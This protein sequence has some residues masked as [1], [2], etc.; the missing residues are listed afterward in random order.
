MIATRDSN[1]KREF[2]LAQ[3]WS[4]RNRKSSENRQIVFHFLPPKLF[5]R[6][7]PIVIRTEQL[8]IF[9]IA[10]STFGEWTLM[11]KLKKKLGIA[12]SS[13]SGI[14]IL[15]PMPISR[16]DLRLHSSWNVSRL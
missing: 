4:S 5:N 13:C 7:Q 2:D 6:P 1:S 12:L 11:L 14:F 16:F 10:Q 15:A 9:D 3:C 8:K